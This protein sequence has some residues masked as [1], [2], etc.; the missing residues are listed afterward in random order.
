MRSFLE[1][2]ESRQFFAAGQL[3]TSFGVGGIVRTAFEDDTSSIALTVA[4][5]TDGRLLVLGRTDRGYDTIAV[6]LVRYLPTGQIDSTFAQN[7]VLEL[8]ISRGGSIAYLPDPAATATGKIYVSVANRLY[9]F[10]DSGLPDQSF[11]GGDGEIDTPT[12]EV[13]I[14]SA[15]RILLR[16]GSTITRLNSDGSL[17][18]SFATNG[19]FDVAP[20]FTDKREPNVYSADITM[21]RAGRI[22]LV[23]TLAYGPGYDVYATRLLPD[24]QLDTGFGLGGTIVIDA[25][26]EIANSVAI[27]RDGKILISAEHEDGGY[28][29]LFRLNSGGLPDEF[30]GPPTGGNMPGIVQLGGFSSA[31]VLVQNNGRILIS[32]TT[33]P[34]TSPNPEVQGLQ[35]F[36]LLPT[37]ELDT[38]FASTGRSEVAQ[39][40]TEYPAGG[41][42]VL[43]ENGLVIVGGRSSPFTPGGFVIARFQTGKTGPGKLNSL[44]ATERAN[45]FALNGP[46]G[47]NHPVDDIMQADESV[48][49]LTD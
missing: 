33:W 34:F 36:R 37:S 20:L 46:T 22:L 38:S 49:L 1:R 25:Y 10:S 21:D 4:E 24:G 32:G 47:L 6:R 42:S 35:A 41:G 11:G 39:F 31:Q 13:Q 28:S 40:D 45:P 48:G 15:G 23:G 17:D 3:E 26:E 14:D 12:S 7:G 44:T 19:V 27:Q 18:T 8:P 9:R 5:Q 2:L 30:G 29:Y 43:T 16:G